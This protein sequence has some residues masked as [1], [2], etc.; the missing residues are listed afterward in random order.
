M[1]YSWKEK[2]A[3][4]WKNTITDYKSRRILRRLCLCLLTAIAFVIINLLQV[5]GVIGLTLRMICIIMLLVI[6]YLSVAHK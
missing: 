1:N 3:E 2:L 6:L 5:P 4:K